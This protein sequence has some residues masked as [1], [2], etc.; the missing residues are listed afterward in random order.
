MR[1]SAFVIGFAL[2][3]VA[4]TRTNAALM[5]ASPSAKLASTCPEAV[6]LY[7]SADKVP[8]QYREV[9]L[10]NS[11][12]STGFTS[13]GGMVKSMRKKAAAV[14]ANGI[15]LQDIKEPNAAT[16]VVGAFLGTGS[17]RKGKS[18]AIYV[19]ADS[20]KTQAACVAA[21]TN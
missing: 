1:R 9:A 5:D 2:A 18:V 6:T 3:V 19:M 13:E 7:S 17:E 20:A 8:G 11:T 21:Q 16:K 4:C 12:G 10:L 15:I 14:G